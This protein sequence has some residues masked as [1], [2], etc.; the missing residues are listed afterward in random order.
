M[1]RSDEFPL[2]PDVAASLAA[3]DATLRG[4]LVDPEHAELAE[5]TVLLAADRP[6]IDPEF[7]TKLD[8]QVRR[9]FATS[10]HRPSRERGRLWALS[11]VAT[12]AAAGLATLLVLEGSSSAPVSRTGAEPV[13]L[14]AGPAKSATVSSARTPAPSNAAPSN[15]APSNAVP[16]AGSVVPQPPL[17]GHRIVQ[18]AQLALTT[19]PA[20][21]EDV[22]QQVFT[23]VGADGGS[24]TSSTVTAT[25]G[26]DSY[27]QFE[28]SVPSANLADAMMRLSRL[29]GA[30]VASRTDTTQ[31]VNGQYLSLSRRVGEAQALRTALLRQL[32][33]ATTA[34]QISSLNAQIRDA[35]ATISRYQAAVNSLNHQ[36]DYTPISLTIDSGRVPVAGRGFTLGRASHDAGRV[37]TVAAGVALIALAAL[38]P[39]ALLVVLCWWIFVALRR[40]RREQAL[41]LA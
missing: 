14:T 16:P 33:N 3:V 8:G 21:M 23:V 5:L 32:A 17:G 22:A 2:D 1:R 27:A 38:V 36:I 15:A 34:A 18:T 24:V 26:P 39:V 37:L 11:G 35:D 9:R 40:R 7:A 12:A 6:R 25:G 30:S 41:D 13:P 29:R 20:Q 31:D 28:L 10:R 19:P 4:D